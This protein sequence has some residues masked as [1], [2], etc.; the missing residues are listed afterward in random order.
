[1]TSRERAK[2]VGEK[3]RANYVP[4]HLPRVFTSLRHDSALVVQ[5]SAEARDLLALVPHY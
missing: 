5:D 4:L 3:A 2:S 1:V